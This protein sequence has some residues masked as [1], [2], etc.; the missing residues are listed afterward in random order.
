[1]SDQDTEE[2]PTTHESDKGNTGDIKPPT[3]GDDPPPPTE[4]KDEE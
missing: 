2:D 3:R 4:G 1:M